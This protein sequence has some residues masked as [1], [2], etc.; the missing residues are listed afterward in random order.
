MLRVFPFRTFDEIAALGLQVEIYC[1][2]CYRYVGPINLADPR[3]HGRLF[4]STRFVCS[5]TRRIYNE[6]RVCGCL[7]H[8]VVRP[9]PADFIPP[10]RSIPWCSI[11]CPRCVPTWEISQAA[12]HLPPWNAIWTDP[13]IRLAWPACR[14]PLTTS[15]SGGE[16]IPHTDGYQRKA[17][18]PVLR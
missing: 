12:K 16:G 10:A 4:V 18:P 6:S 5:R 7:G 11:S 1:G 2:G 9:R 15:W 8:I 3:L 17:K 14:S 13:D